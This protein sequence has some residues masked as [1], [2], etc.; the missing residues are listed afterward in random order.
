MKIAITCLNLSWQSGGPRLIFSLA[1]AEKAKG[2]NVV[3]YA[4]EF[5]GL[6]F[7]ELYEG[8]DIR[9]V[10]PKEELRWAGLPKGLVSRIFDK[11]AENRKRLAAMENIAN[12]MDADFDV[13][14]VHDFSY[15]VGYFYKK[16][17][18]RTRIVWTENDPPFM[19]MPKES[20]LLDVVARVYNTAKEFS[21]KKYFRVIDAVSVLDTFNENWCKV[22]GLKPTIVRLGVDAQKFHLPVKDFTKKAKKKQATLFSLGS[23]NQ[24]RHYEDMI[25]AAKI[26]RDMGYDARIKLIANDMWNSA[27][28]RD[29]IV[30]LVLNSGLKEFTDITFKGAPQDELMQAYRET[31]V[32]IYPMYLP[33]PR[34]GF[35]FSIGVFEAMAAGLPV[36]LCNTTTSTEVLKDGVSALFVDPEHPDQ[37]AEKVKLLIDNPEQYK[38]IATAA[39]KL[40]EEDLTWEKYADGVLR[41][42]TSAKTV[43]D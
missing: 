34:S 33:P 13:V 28:Y 15:P 23:L 43:A 40:V 41:L 12:A 20:F 32:F 10:P 19:Y 1:R 9:V 6:Y 26:L 22:R 39:Q 4:P 38:S 27:E 35:G 17:N 14:N 30:S 36:V 31:D 2:H 24:Y 11:L 8:L 7:K 5:A 42:V 3:I 18:S 16:R 25:M 37:I 29:K 21:E